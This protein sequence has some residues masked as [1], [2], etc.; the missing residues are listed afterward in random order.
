MSAAEPT[1]ASAAGAP[2][3]QVTVTNTYDDNG[4]LTF[5]SAVDPAAGPDIRNTQYFYDNNDRQWKVIDPESG[6][7]TRGYDAVGNVSNVVDQNGNDVETVYDGRNLP[8][9][10]WLRGFVDPSTSDPARDIRTAL[11]TYDDAGRLLTATDAEGR[12]TQWTYDG[13]DR[14]DTVTLLAY[15][16]LDGTTRNVLLSDPVYDGAGNVVSETRG[17]GAANQLAQVPLTD[18]RASGRMRRLVAAV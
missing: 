9:E 5:V 6:V 18:Q 15:T 8:I 17:D 1:V 12:V 4:N 3:S 14:I 7:L 13:A 11:N 2:A 16:D 10:V